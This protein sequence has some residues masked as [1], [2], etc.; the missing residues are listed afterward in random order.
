MC[1]LTLIISG[2][3]R[4]TRNL[5]IDMRIGIHSGSILAG[6]IGSAKLQYDIWGTVRVQFAF[7]MTDINL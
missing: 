7:G 1:L 3:F 2:H 5:E 6:V 4:R